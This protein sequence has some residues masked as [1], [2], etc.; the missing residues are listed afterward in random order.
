MPSRYLQNNLIFLLF[1]LLV[2]FL[3]GNLF[4]TVL[5]FIRGFIIWDGF[6]IATLLIVIEFTSYISYKP[7]H[8]KYFRAS[9]FTLKAIN[10][11]KVGFMI[12][13]FVDAFKVGS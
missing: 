3:S 2:G 1:V 13:F 10:F 12:G 4:G 9:Y 8:S 7:R 11:F 6:I 5:T